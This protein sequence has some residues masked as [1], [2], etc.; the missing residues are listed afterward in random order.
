VYSLPLG[1]VRVTERL[2]RS[3]PLRNKHWKRMKKQIDHDLR[4][5]LRQPAHRAEIMVGSGG[6]FTAFAHMSKWEREGRHGSVQ[7]YVL[8]PAEIIHLL[9]RLREAPLEARR[10]IPGL[11]PDRA[12]IILAGATVIA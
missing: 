1:A 12:D 7:G 6:S 4:A 5:A 2:V 8:T 10:R 9:D 11:S 3:D